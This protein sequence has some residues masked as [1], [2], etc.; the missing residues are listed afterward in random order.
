MEQE[1]P[2]LIDRRGDGRLM[3]TMDDWRQ[4]FPGGRGHSKLGY[5]IFAGVSKIQKISRHVEDSRPGLRSLSSMRYDM[6]V[7]SGRFTVMSRRQ[8]LVLGG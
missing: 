4:G 8:Y 2:V 7:G 6:M 1:A 5:S 3:L